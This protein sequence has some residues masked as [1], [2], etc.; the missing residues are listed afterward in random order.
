MN[1]QW[2]IDTVGTAS[3]WI[4]VTANPYNAV[5]DGVADD[6]AAIQSAIDAAEATLMPVF[7]PAGIYKIATTLTYKVP[8]V[9]V[10]RITVT[11]ARGGSV[12][13]GSVLLNSGAINGGSAM[14]A[15]SGA[16]DRD[17]R[18][19][20]IQFDGAQ[21]ACVGV[22]GTSNVARYFMENCSFYECDTA[23]IDINA[24]TATIV[25]CYSR[26]S[27]NGYILRAAHGV[28]IVG[29]E[30][31]G[32]TGIGL[33]LAELTDATFQLNIAGLV[34]ETATTGTTGLRVGE[35]CKSI[36][37]QNLYF[38]GNTNGYHIQVAWGGTGSTTNAVDNVALK[39]VYFA[40][41]ASP[42]PSLRFGNINH[43]SIDNVTHNGRVEFAATCRSVTGTIFGEAQDQSQGTRYII[44]QQI[45]D[46]TRRMG[47]PAQNIVVNP[48]FGGSAAN[49]VRGFTDV[50]L[51]GVTCDLESSTSICRNGVA[52]LKVTTAS[53]NT[54]ISSQL[55]AQFLNQSYLT[56]VFSGSSGE[57]RRLFMTCW[58]RLASSAVYAIGGAYDPYLAL[59]W[60]ND[61]VYETANASTG[62]TAS[63]SPGL[64]RWQRIVVWADI[65]LDGSVYDRFGWRVVTRPQNATALAADAVLYIADLVVCVDPQSTED[66]LAG[67]YDSASPCGYMVGS[68][69][70]VTG[71]SVPTDANI[72]WAVG[73]TVWNTAPAAAGGTLMWVC[74]T[75]GTGATAVF[76]ALALP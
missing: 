54:N 43:L 45:T 46:A 66:I 31:Q 27:A 12:S 29:G 67:R 53:G 20:N 18:L 35:G 22:K 10:E 40:T 49:A 30:I 8:M 7:L 6:T 42:Y 70:H 52:C 68:K 59:D 50:D 24:N 55:S 11:D 63:D 58:V 4:D 48:N 38:E 19:R 39:N 47:R 1:E 15:L 3:G 69:I 2:I 74:T 60:R 36:S 16:A 28:T 37:L 64:N 23:G 5:G 76:T 61:G 56:A 62:C 32:Y 72:Q 13:K 34:I 51:T 14:L 44:A 57:K 17:W 65:L 71:A 41:T 21:Q 33:D 75:A 26:Y 73:D 9:G 25:N